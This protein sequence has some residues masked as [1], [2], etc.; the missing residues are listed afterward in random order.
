MVK[1]CCNFFKHYYFFLC[2]RDG[3]QTICY[4]DQQSAYVSYLGNNYGLLYASDVLR[5]MEMRLKLVCFLISFTYLFI[6]NF[7][8]PYQ[9]VNG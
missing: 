9:N 5:T 6:L 4:G 2:K 1:N 8:L 3:I 7:K